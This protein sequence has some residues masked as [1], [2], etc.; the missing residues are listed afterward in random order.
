MDTGTALLLDGR[1]TCEDQVIP[2]SDRLFSATPESPAEPAPSSTRC[3]VTSAAAAPVD[4]RERAR[5]RA[6]GLPL[7]ETPG[8]PELIGPGGAA[9]L[10]EIVG[11]DR[12]EAEAAWRSW[13]DEVAASWA[14]CL[15]ADLELAAAAV[16]APA[17]GPLP[18]EFRGGSRNLTAGR[19]PPR[20]VRCR[21]A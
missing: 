19:A 6:I 17:G 13:V 21:P 5:A 9:R 12:T 3:C 2:D 7:P 8:S 14:A 16:D 11:T 4:R 15:L 10:D 18:V 20:P 1:T